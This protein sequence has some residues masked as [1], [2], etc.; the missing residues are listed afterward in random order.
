MTIP[1]NEWSPISGGHIAGTNLAWDA[2]QADTD[3]MIQ[4]LIALLKPFWGADTSFSSYVINTY[5]DELSP[6]RPQVA[7]GLTGFVGTG[8]AGIPA[9][10]STFNFKTD[11]FGTFKLVMLDGKVSSTFQPLDA[12]TSPADDDEL[13]L[14]AYLVNDAWAFAGRDNHQ[15]V[16][17]KRITYTLN[18]KLRKS[19]RLD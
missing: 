15:P 11:I 10:Q 12:L 18:E 8:D 17:L 5:A 9:A 14:V 4:G 2:S 3:D 7:V 6:A 19:Y 1:L 13:A 16:L